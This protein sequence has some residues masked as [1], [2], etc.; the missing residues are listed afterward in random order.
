MTPERW[1]QIDKLLGQALEHAPDRRAAFLDEA[2]LGDAGLR[3]EVESVLAA[4]EQAG[5]PLS[6]PA[7]GVANRKPGDSPQSLVGQS[8]SHY[9]IPSHLGEGG[10]GIVY[11]ARDQGHG[12]L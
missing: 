3:Q 2:C 8:L 6:A 5:N 12:S 7:I 9:Q 10:M 1:Q 4:H 11:K